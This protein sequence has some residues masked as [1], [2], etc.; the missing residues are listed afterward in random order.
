[1][2]ATTIYNKFISKLFYSSQKFINADFSIKIVALFGLAN[3]A[4]ILPDISYLFGSNALIQNA[5]NDQHIFWYQPVFYWFTDPLANLGIPENITILLLIGV[6]IFS[7]LGM[8]F[9]RYRFTS[10]LL[11]WFIHLLI[12]NSNFLFAYGADNMVSTL[13]FITIF[14]CVPFKDVAKK[15]MIYSFAIRFL[16]VQMC[17]IYFFG[18]LGKSLGTD[19][20]DGNAI[21]YVINIYSSD[22]VDYAVNFVNYPIVFKIICWSVVF[23][24]LLYPFLIY[25]PKIKRFVLSKIILLHILIGIF[26]HLYTFAVVMILLNLIAFGHYYKWFKVKEKSESPVLA[27]DMV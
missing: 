25:V 9:N 19:W 22:Y 1:M 7:F 21:W 16:Q 2:E 13:L 4:I 23:V 18:G 5:V 10:A 14:F 27:I 12:V 11:A 26:M 20:F 6:Y 8:F 15:N 17:F 3:I 24:E